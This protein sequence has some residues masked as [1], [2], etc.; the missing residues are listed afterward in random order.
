VRYQVCLLVLLI[1]AAAS[2]QAYAQATDTDRSLAQSLFDQGKR[3]M[4]AGKFADA[5]PKLEES[6][7]LD[8]AGGTLLNLALCHEH[9]EKV[10]TAWTD[11]KAAL[12]AA[13][14]D[15]RQD[16]IDAAE[17]HITAL[18]P[19]LPW[20]TITVTD[21]APGQELKLDGALIGQAAWGTAVSIDPGN[22]ELSASA[23]GRKQ[24]TSNVTLAIS[25]RESMNVPALAIAP[26][27]AAFTPVAAQ[28]IVP[29]RPAVPAPE[30]QPRHAPAALGY[31]TTGWLIGGAGV[32]ATGVGVYFGV[33]TFSKKK[34]SD[35]LCPTDLTC[36]PQG[37]AL[38]DE[39]HSSAW[40][41]DVAIGVGLA[42]IGAG[43]YLLLHEEG[44]TTR[45]EAPRT[46][47]RTP[48]KLD[49]TVLPGGGQ[50]SVTRDW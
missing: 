5:C 19:K 24:W 28:P 35:A 34:Q 21:A 42:A 39:A 17:Q 18:E 7:R 29:A 6:E 43:V 14:R 47:A 20:L 50:I 40:I 44:A 15:G 37:A 41:S 23:P 25:A 11:F 4:D 32:V 22:H 16:R 2:R 13:R 45:A 49:A 33:R 27:Q 31:Q 3:L 8:P 10:A 46:A 1:C 26:E 38:N 9:E 36:T 48:L 12:G 30:P